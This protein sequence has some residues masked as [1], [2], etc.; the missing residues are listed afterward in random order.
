[1]PLIEQRE[2]T[3]KG[4]EVSRVSIALGIVALLRVV[5]QRRHVANK[6]ELANAGLQLVEP[7]QPIQ[8]EPLALI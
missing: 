5:P 7:H 1:M 8:N 3:E 2:I 4:P 6:K